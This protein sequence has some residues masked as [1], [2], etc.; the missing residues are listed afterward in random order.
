MRTKKFAVIIVAI[1]FVLVMLF[2][3]I[4]LFA[5]K[6][7]KVN[8]AVGD[9]TE[10]SKVQEKL[11]EFLGDSLVFLD[12]QEIVDSLSEFHYMEV[13]SV[14]KDYPNA[15]NVE[16]K[17]RR[18]VYEIVSDESVYVTTDDGFVLRTYNINEESKSR[19]RIRLVLNGVTV[20]DSALGKIIKTDGDELLKQ[21]FE[22]AKS[23]QLTNCIDTVELIKAPQKEIATFNTYT[24]V[25][26]IIREILD[27]GVKKIETAFEKY[28]KGTT[29]YEKTFNKIVVVKLTE[30]GEIIATWTDKE[31]VATNA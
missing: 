22:M 30:T 2:S 17:E 23:V 6:E 1:V 24:G 4:A 31:D 26:I 28:D 20:S 12:E 18:E 9:S 7:V 5:V 3:C 19:D 13:V 10:T 16:I 21:V 25:K 15:I 14:T 11:E 8:Y 27:D 29:D